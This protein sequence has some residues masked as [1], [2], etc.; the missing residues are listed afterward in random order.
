[1]TNET[2]IKDLEAASAIARSAE[3]SPLLGKPFSLMWGL[4]LTLVLGLQYTLLEQII[5]APLYWIAVLWIAFGVIGGIGNVVIGRRQDAMAGSNSTGNKVE[6]SVW[7]MF[8]AVMATAFLAAI[9]SIVLGLQDQTVWGL[10]VV[11]GFLGQGLAY[12][13]TTRIQSS[14][15]VTFSGIAALIAGAVALT[16]HDKTTVYLVG[17]IGSFVALVVPS[18][19]RKG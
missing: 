3:A 19:L 4:L 18:L 14:G 5:T 16:V 9:A 12:G 2:L 11:F 17:A 13:T 6:N 10:I 7:I 1:M 15:I 8:A